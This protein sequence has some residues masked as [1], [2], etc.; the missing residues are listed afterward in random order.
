M[1]FKSESFFIKIDF[2]LKLGGS[3]GVNENRCRD[4]VTAICEGKIICV[5]FSS[6]TLLEKRSARNT[7]F[8]CQYR[9]NIR[10]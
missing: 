4:V 5:F 6:K 1:S 10:I 9:W 3:E 7:G 2:I 8:K